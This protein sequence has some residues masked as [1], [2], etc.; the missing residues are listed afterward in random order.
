MEGLT[1]YLGIAIV[2]ALLALVAALLLYQYNQRQEPGT[3]RM[4]E[5]AGMIREGALAFLSSEYAW[6]VPFVVVVF[7][8]LL[9]FYTWQTAIAFVVGA[10]FSALAGNIGMR[11]AT[12]SSVRTTNAARKGLLPALRIAFNSGSVMGLSVVGLGILGLSFLTWWYASQAGALDQLTPVFNTYILGFSLGASSI[13]LFARVG[14]GIYTKAADVGADLVGKV[15]A[16]IPED[17]PRNPAVIADNVG[18]NVGDVAGMGADLYES[19]VGSIVSAM[20][21]GYL[22]FVLD[23]T[24]TQEFALGMHQKIA[25][26]MFPLLLVAAGTVASLIGIAFVNLFSASN[27]HAALRNG[28]IA[29]AVLTLIF[30]AAIIA[31]LKLLWVLLGVIFLGL[32]AGTMIAWFT[33]YYTSSDYKPTRKLSEICQ[34]GTAP[35]IINGIA[36]GMVS[37]AWPLIFIVIA[38]AGSYILAGGFNAPIAGLYGIALAA[39]GML[40][41]LG[42]TLAV[43]AYGPVADNAGGIA[44]MSELDPEVRS[45][46]DK[47][48]AVGNTTAAIGKGFAIGS[49]AL[50]A[51][52]FFA[53]YSQQVSHVTQ[54]ESFALNLIK[55]SVV[56]GLLVGAMLPFLFCSL[57]LRA[58]GDAAGE[59]IEEVRRQFREIPGLLEGKAKGD[60]SRCVSISTKAALRRMVVPGL[61]ALL[62]PIVVGLV[63]RFIGTLQGEAGKAMGAEAVGGLLAGAVASGVM[64]A[65]FM[66]NAG[67]AWDNAKKYIEEGHFGGKGSEPHKAAVVG[68]TV[69]DPFK[70][71]AGPSLNILIKL[72]SIV[73]L[74]FA[75]LFVAG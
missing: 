7:L 60:V 55:P 59:M 48:D 2:V 51:L 39:V 1:L 61:L 34:M 35:N 9:I 17:D 26:A 16:G 12:I 52:A 31:W 13:A 28:T 70:D 75:S 15:E 45:I 46:T 44:T 69:G 23:P 74:V 54:L 4:Q 14:G 50:T 73:A 68:D 36:V 41:T 57:A 10:F 18:D 71:T 53:A 38:I 56:V 11:V 22:A 24:V 33:E 42:V 21:L 29:A 8:I 47:L 62:S 25:L 66:A 5:I 32:L 72:M 37:V 20:L 65:L 67:G 64:L 49:A 58:V 30:S 40:S 63:F 27:P 19:F 6:L 43:D 3:E